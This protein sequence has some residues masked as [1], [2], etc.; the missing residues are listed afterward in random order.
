MTLN[1]PEKLRDLDMLAIP[2]DFLPLKSLAKE[3][4]AAHPNMY[5]KSGQKILCAARMIARDPRLFGL[6]VTNFACGPDSYLLKFFS[7]ATEGKPFLTIEIDEHSADAGIITRCEAFIDTIRNA[8]TRGTSQPI[9]VVS[10]SSN[11]TNSRRI[12]LPYMIDHGY[13]IA[14]AMRHCGADAEPLPQSDELTLEL[15]RKYTTG[16]EC[17]PSIITTGDIVKKTLAPGF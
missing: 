14:A 11:H 16:K 15:G 4:S 8:R 10:I 1:L 6:Y 9:P 12:Y 2:L 7:K 17:Y 3:V 13:V 5:W